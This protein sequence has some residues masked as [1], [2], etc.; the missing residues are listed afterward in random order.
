MQKNT[1]KSVIDLDILFSNNELNDSRVI[2]TLQ[3][4]I[5]C[6]K[7][8]EIFEARDI[9]ISIVDAITKLEENN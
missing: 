7:N 1:I 4:A 5:N 2:A 6:Y 3:K 8:G 9:L